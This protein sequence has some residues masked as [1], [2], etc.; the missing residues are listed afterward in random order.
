[1]SG[2]LDSSAVDSVMEE[3][4]TTKTQYLSGRNR[5]K[6]KRRDEEEKNGG[7]DTE[8]EEEEEE[9]DTEVWGL[10]SKSFKQV[11]AVLDQNR[12][13][14]QMV[15]E[16]HRSLISENLAKNPALI[17]EINGNISKV[18]SLYSDLSVNFSSIVRQRRIKDE[19][20]AQSQGS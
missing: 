20:A 5:R 18:L 8:D 9:Y 14:I 1:M 19:T 4:S 17:R 12:E 7:G 11:Q 3:D 6:K 10:L 15:N 13:L 2:S 16:N